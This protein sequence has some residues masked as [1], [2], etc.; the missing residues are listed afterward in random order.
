MVAQG[1]FSY[2]LQNV[3]LGAGG[4][5]CRKMASRITVQTWLLA[6]VLLLIIDILK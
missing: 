5:T 3:R 1:S 4:S 2:N 6:E